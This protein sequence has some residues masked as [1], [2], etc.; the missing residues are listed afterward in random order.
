MRPG[1]DFVRPACRRGF[2]VASALAVVL[3][4]ASALPD[5]LAKDP[6]SRF[7]LGGFAASAVLAWALR[8]VPLRV[9]AVN[10]GAVLLV[11]AAFERWLVLSGGEASRRVVASPVVEGDLVRPDLVLGYAP[12][13][14]ATARMVRR[15]GER[16]LYDA[17]ASIGRDGF[18]IAPPPSVDPPDGTLLLAGCS[19]AYGEGLNDAETLP[20]RLA[21]ETGRRLL[22]RNLSFSGWGPHQLLALVES[23][24][25]LAGVPSGRPLIVLYEALADHVPRALGRRP[26]SRSTPRYVLGTSGEIVRDGAFGELSA[27][28]ERWVTFRRVLGSER[29]ISEREVARVVAILARTRELVLRAHDGA[30]FEVLLWDERDALT[31]SYRSAL[32]A[33]GFPVHD[34]SQILPGYPADRGWQLPDDGH[35]TAAANARLA[36]ALA[37]VVLRPGSTV[38]ESPERPAPPLLPPSAPSPRPTGS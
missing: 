13:R 36:R 6:W 1:A 7:L 4:L 14:G 30:R 22:V 5:P 33:A 21:E 35:P 10:F 9:A 3:V 2:V 23:G 34:V 29:R 28:L 8:P 11:L 20:W 31:G 18:R 32:A 12:A 27:P 26:W 37:G 38:S 25:A 24:R 17:R 19:F 15:R 16:L